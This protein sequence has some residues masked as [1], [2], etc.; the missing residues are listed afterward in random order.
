MFAFQHL[1]TLTAPLFCL[2]LIGYVLTR[3]G[4]WPREVSDALTRFVFAVAVTRCCF[5]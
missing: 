3:W 5:A 4:G 2:V 1:I